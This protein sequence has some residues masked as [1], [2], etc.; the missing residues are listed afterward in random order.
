M[1]TTI[2]Y[3]QLNP[4][5]WKH[6]S[7]LAMVRDWFYPEHISR[8][9]FDLASSSHIDRRQD[10]INLV[11]LWRFHE[12]KLNHALIS[13][14]NLTDAILH[15]QPRKRDNLSGLA[16]RSIYAMAF[17]RFVNALV[18][19]DVRKSTTT[20]I[21]KD[22]VAADADAG[23]GPHRGQSSMYAH[24]LEL[25]LPETFVE[26]RHQAIHEEMPSL[27][28]LR[29]RTGEA[30]EWLWQRWWKFNVK[31]SAQPGLSEWEVR[32]KE[33]Q[34][35]AQEE[36]GQNQLGLCQRHRKRKL[37]DL[38]GDKGIE[39]NAG[40]GAKHGYH[41]LQLPKQQSLDKESE[42]HDSSSPEWQGWVMHFS[43]GSGGLSRLKEAPEYHQD[44]RDSLPASSKGALAKP[45]Y[46]A[47][48]NS[49]T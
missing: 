26:L 16:L 38:N 5:P 43:K 13:T 28:V 24:A 40:T 15:D 46:D 3:S 17:C 22:T 49:N 37:S 12:P 7:E 9:F 19:R 29:M 34:S 32:H 10:A 6:P 4:A 48:S 11:S 35:V 23:S 20:T 41:S 36:G 14:A 42:S 39:T 21:A 8:N 44:K 31:G 30:L 27:E 45:E 1:L 33:W 25:G 47:R 18:D 2:P